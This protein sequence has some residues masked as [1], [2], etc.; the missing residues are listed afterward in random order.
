MLDLN[1]EEDSQAEV[2]FNVVM[3]G[4]GLLVEVQGTAEGD[5]FGRDQLDEMLGLAASGIERLTAIQLEAAG[6]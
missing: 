5:P 2:D 3:T 1:Y 6:A 4:S